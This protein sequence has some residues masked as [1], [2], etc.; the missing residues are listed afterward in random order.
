MK[1]Q[2]SFG[3]GSTYTYEIDSGV[4]IGDTVLTPAPFWDAMSGPRRA[5]VVALESGY[6]GPLARAWLPPQERATAG[7]GVDQALLDQQRDGAADGAG[8]QPG[9]LGD[10]GQRRED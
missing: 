7:D 8:S 3:T 1:I 6:A 5:K 10:L 2:V 4:Q 9:L